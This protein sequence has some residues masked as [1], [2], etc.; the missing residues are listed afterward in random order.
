VA[1]DGCMTL[2]GTL[3]ATGTLL[4]LL[5]I[6]AVFGWQCVRQ[7]IHFPIRSELRAFLWL[8]I[9]CII[10]GWCLVIVTVRRP[11]WSTKTAP[12]YAVLKGFFLGSF[13]AVCEVRFPGIVL[14]ALSLTVLICATLLLAYGSG[15]IRVTE[16]FNRKL[17]VAISAV[18]LFY[19]VNLGMALAGIPS[20][21]SRAGIVPSIILSIVTTGIASMSLISDFD[22]AVKCASAGTRPKYL[23]WYA[24]IGI[25]L[26]L[27]WMYIEV[28]NLITK[29]REAEEAP[30]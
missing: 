29:A 2:D 9:I 22:S 12:V 21:M 10:A 18:V 25:L 19:L 28:L 8:T 4:T 27:I 30:Y 23:E 15:W 1:S 7:M 13:S 26:S 16:S 20:L 6:G 24:A 5:L 17:S 3:Y 14:Q 11:A